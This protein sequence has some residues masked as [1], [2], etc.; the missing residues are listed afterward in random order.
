MSNATLD[1]V[2]WYFKPEKLYIRY[3]NKPPIEYSWAQ[4]CKLLNVSPLDKPQGL[5]WDGGETG[6][7][8]LDSKKKLPFQLLAGRLAPHLPGG[9]ES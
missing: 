7:F 5:F 9:L 4:I 6:Y 8:T 3:K 1:E 2:S